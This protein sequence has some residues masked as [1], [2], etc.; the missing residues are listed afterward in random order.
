LKEEW[1]IPTVG[2]EFVWRMEDVLDLYAE[3]LDEKRPVV[4]FD[5]CPYQLVGEVRAEVLANSEHA[6]RID[7][8]YKRNGTCNLFVAVQPKGGWRHVALTERR[9][10]LDFAKQLKELSDVHF[11]EADVI[12]LVLDNLNIHAPSALYEAFLPGEARRLVSRFEFHYTPKHGSWLNV[13]EIELSVLGH[14]CIDRRIGSTDR[15]SAE[16]A[17]WENARNAN[18]VTINWL[19]STE[20]ARTK[21]SKLY[22]AIP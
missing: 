13:A 5:E 20:N 10:K 12:R 6:R 4:G 3:P 1:C 21:L 7:Y 17:A 11:P 22:P 18:H 9:T 8:E 2:S 16:V 19:F 14:Q 15:L